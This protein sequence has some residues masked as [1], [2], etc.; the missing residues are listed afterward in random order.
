MADTLEGWKVVYWVDG[1]AGG[2]KPGIVCRDPEMDRQTKT[3]ECYGPS[4]SRDAFES[5]IQIVGYTALVVS[6]INLIVLLLVVIGRLKREETGYGALYVPI[7]VL[8][9]WLPAV[10]VASLI[11][12][13]WEKF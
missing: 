9:A 13:A 2:D 11:D 7:M 5:G 1:E 8:S 12:S 10:V 3:I 4:Q 6:A